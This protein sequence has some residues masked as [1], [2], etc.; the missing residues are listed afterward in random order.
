MLTSYPIDIK[1]LAVIANC[2][3]APPTFIECATNRIFIA[4]NYDFN[5][6]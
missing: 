3:V 4:S 2:F 1:E 6:K 5:G